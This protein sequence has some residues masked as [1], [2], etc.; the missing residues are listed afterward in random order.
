MRRA[1][2][3]LA[4]IAVLGLVAARCGSSSPTS[5]STIS[6]VQSTPASASPVQANI[7]SVLP[8]VLPPS[9]STQTLIVTGSNFQQ[10]MIV[11]FAQTP[12]S[13]PSKLTDSTQTFTGSA[14]QNLTDTSF[15]ISVAVSGAGTY[16]VSVTNPSSTPSTPATVT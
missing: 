13:T 1:P 8:A 6:V 11:S 5:P 12:S 2:G 14:I 15:Q 16:T 4:L 9:T 3:R 10:G 7:S